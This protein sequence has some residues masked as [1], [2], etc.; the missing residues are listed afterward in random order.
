MQTT[1]IEAYRWIIESGQVGRQQAQ[2]LQ[3]FVN[4]YNRAYTNSEVSR[5]TGIKVSTV[6]PRMKELRELGHLV[7]GGV[8]VCKVSGFSAKCWVLADV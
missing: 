4:N 1:S 2:I 7:C 3:F 5:Y 8:R 6:C